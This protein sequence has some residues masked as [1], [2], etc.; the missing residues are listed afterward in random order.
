MKRSLLSFLFLLVGSFLWPGFSPDIVAQITKGKV[1]TVVEQEPEFPG[2]T[3]ALSRYLAEN[4]RVPG[5]LVRKN[6]NAGPI[7]AKFIIDELGYVHD[8]RIVAQPIEGKMRKGMEAF[9]AN[10][11]VAV[12]KMPRWTPGRVAGKPVPVFYTLPVEVNMQ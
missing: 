1:Y 12:E 3:V 6:Y 2:G 11:I 5:A 4:I 10:I 9:M 7:A 8:P